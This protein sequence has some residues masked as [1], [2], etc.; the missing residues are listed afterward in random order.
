MQNCKLC[1]YNFHKLWEK[2][3]QKSDDTRV[4]ISTGRAQNMNIGH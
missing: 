3:T 2:G 1:D 4:A